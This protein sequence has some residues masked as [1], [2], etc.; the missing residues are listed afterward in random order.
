VVV[1]VVLVLDVAD[2]SKLFGL[3]DVVADVSKLFG[4]LDVVADVSKLF[5]L[6]DVVAEPVADLVVVIVPLEKLLDFD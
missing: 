3:L 1:V 6:L 5:G 2:V 4:L